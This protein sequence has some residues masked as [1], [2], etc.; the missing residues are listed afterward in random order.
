[1]AIF[2]KEFSFESTEKTYVRRITPLINEYIAET[3]TDAGI[4]ILE[5]MHTTCGFNINEG[6]EP[7]F[8][9]DIEEQSQLL[10][11]EDENS[12]W[13]YGRPDYPFPT[14]QYR[15]FCGDN[16]LLLP[17]EI[18]NESNGPRHLRNMVLAYP[19]LQR[20]YRKGGLVLKRFQDILFLEF[21]GRDG[22]NG[23]EKRER[24]FL[25]TVNS[26]E[27]PIIPLPPHRLPPN[28]LI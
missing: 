26:Y 5:S 14:S 6:M 2:E 4:I 13:A 3:K 28:A 27:S 1:M 8:L 23:L 15:H 25:L 20:S 10:F 22:S 16:R 24:S 18:E 9:K 7:N 21:D 12:T 19:T 11:H 17:G